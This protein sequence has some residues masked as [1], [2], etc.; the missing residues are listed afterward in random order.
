MDREYIEDRYGV[1]REELD[2]ACSACQAAD[3]LLHLFCQGGE[4]EM[5]SRVARALAAHLEHHGE[6]D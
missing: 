5:A 6:E 3:A 2:G 1:D 4:N